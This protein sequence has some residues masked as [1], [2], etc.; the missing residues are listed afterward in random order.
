MPQVLLRQTVV[1]LLGGAALLF[2]ISVL[3]FLLIHLAPGDTVTNLLGAGPGSKNPAARAALVERWHLDD[4]LWT[5]YWSWLG[6]VLQGD[7]GT[8]IRQQRPVTAVLG[9]PTALSLQLVGLALLIA[10]ALGVPLGVLSARR[11]G[12]RLDQIVSAVAVTGVSAP[13]FAVSFLLIYVFGYR[14]HWFPLYGQGDGALDRLGHLLLP[15]LALAVGLAA[16]TLKIT[17]SVMMRELGQDYVTAARARGWRETRVM[18]LGLRNGAM[19]LVTS[20]GLLFSY[21][22]ANTILVEQSFALPGLGRTLYDAVSYK[23]IPLVQATTL[24]VAAFIVVVSLLAD[25]VAALLDPRT[26]RAGEVSL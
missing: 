13:S 18:R 12:R 9:A 2:V 11:A 10:L 19:P 15:A 25:V 8:S 7:W 16:F 14:L 26:R 23:D 24:L 22:L 1:R 17:R 6:R 4:P 5:Q 3:T 20:T 21:L